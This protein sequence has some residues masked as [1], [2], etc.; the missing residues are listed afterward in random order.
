MPP[1]PPPPPPIPKE[2][3]LHGSQLV[4]SPTASSEED[5]RVGLG[6]R[7]D[8]PCMERSWRV[9]PLLLLFLLLLLLP[10]P[11]PPPVSE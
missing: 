1:P 5:P 10:P 7:G 9:L 8:P 2:L 11:P 3:P 4:C 6:G